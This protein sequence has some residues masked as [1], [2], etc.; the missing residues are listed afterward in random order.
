M[1]PATETALANITAAREKAD[2][3]SKN[4][5]DKAEDSRIATEKAAQAANAVKNAKPADKDAAAKEAKAANEAAGKAAE[6]AKAAADAVGGAAEEVEAAIA[7]HAETVK[8]EKQ[9]EAAAEADKKSKPKGP[10]IVLRPVV[11]IYSVLAIG[12][13]CSKKDFKDSVDVDMLVKKKVLK[14]V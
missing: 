2:E 11:G 13:S 1:S 8:A 9:K 12:D 3:V 6:E 10:Y 7:T 14:K 5:R 4:A